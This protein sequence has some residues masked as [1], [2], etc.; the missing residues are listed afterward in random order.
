M[1]GLQCTD[2]ASVKKSPAGNPAG[3]LFGEN[4]QTFKGYYKYTIEFSLAKQITSSR[5][6]FIC[7]HGFF[8]FIF[9][10]IIEPN[11]LFIIGRR[12]FIV[13]IFDITVIFNQNHIFKF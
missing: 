3:A 7:P 2:G 8:G 10:Y 6:L 9:L 4:F 5:L 11:N 12:W 1:Y 13:V